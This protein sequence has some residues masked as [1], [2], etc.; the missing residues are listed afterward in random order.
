M[1]LF[2]GR[3]GKGRLGTHLI[4]GIMMLGANLAFNDTKKKIKVKMIETYLKEK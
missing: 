2:P 3:Y 1:R 4:M